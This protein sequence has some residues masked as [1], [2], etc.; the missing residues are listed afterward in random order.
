ML[1][2]FQQKKLRRRAFVGALGFGAIAL[3]FL[4]LLN[5]AGAQDGARP[6]RLLVVFSPNGTWPDEWRPEGGETDFRFK[7]ILAPLE[8]HRDR[9]L[10]LGGVSMLSTDRGPGDGH[11][12]GMGHVLT[13]VPL[14]PGDVVGGCDSCPPVSWASDLSVDQAIANEIGGSTRFR[15]LEL[16]AMSPEYANVWTRMSYRARSEPLPPEASPWRA[17]ERVFGDA[18][19]DPDAARR[20]L[21]L[22][23]SVLDHNVAE[24]ERLSARLATPD[25]Q[26]LELH[27]ETIR[28]IERRIGAPGALGAE[29]RI[30]EIG[31][32]IDHRSAENFP[33]IVRLQSDI[34][35]M[36][37][38][39]GLTNVGSIQWTN[40]VGNIP[41]PHLGV[42]EN[43][44]DLSH[45][46]DSNTDAVEK[47]VRINTWYA[48][49]YAYL[50]ERLAST[51]EGEGSMLDNTVVLWVNE[52]GKGNSHTLRDIPFVLAG[53]VAND[54]G[55]PHFRTGRYLQLDGDE[56]PHNDLLVSLCQAFGIETDV[57]GD[58]D[59]C[60]GPLPG[61]T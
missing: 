35:C 48:E 10:V 22:R 59:F 12:K 49:Q 15:S 54:D 23:Q 2:I 24:Y 45:E 5:G 30:P 53:N 31:A 47:L 6:R 27:L 39:C 50:L 17:F 51:P 60:N 29:C 8:P 37:F 16:G 1:P 58:R 36:A 33:E 32:A 18:S 40:S 56:T 14:L 28:D 21:A 11:Q 44:H 43:H 19:V 13:G 26:R 4:R 3:P 41:F 42:T 57:F 20:R 38:A 34:M 52:L 25:R 55:T 9:V 7:R 61:L 46:G